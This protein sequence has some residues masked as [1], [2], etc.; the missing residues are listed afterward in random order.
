MKTPISSP[1]RVVQTI[2]LLALTVIGTKKSDVYRSCCPQSELFIGRIQKKY[3]K[4]HV[5]DMVADTDVK[6]LDIKKISHVD[7]PMTF[8]QVNSMAQCCRQA[9]TANI[10]ARVYYLLSLGAT[11]SPSSDNTHENP[12]NDWNEHRNH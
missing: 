1:S 4:Q 9:S 11:S 5:Q 7:M 6:I 8:I 3:P 10:V 2:E 12:P